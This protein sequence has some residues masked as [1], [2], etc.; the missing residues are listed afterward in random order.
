MCCVYNIIFLAQV[1]FIFEVRMYDIWIE[2]STL[3]ET[4]IF[5]NLKIRE[6]K[7]V[8]GK[9]KIILTVDNALALQIDTLQM[10][11]LIELR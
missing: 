4:I 5:I 10:I 8:G 2:N 3:V 9:T 6:A 7:P 11:K 1:L